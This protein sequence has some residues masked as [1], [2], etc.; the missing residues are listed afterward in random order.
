MHELEKHGDELTFFALE[1]QFR[2]VHIVPWRGLDIALGAF[3]LRPQLSAAAHGAFLS[4]F[5]RHAGVLAFRLTLIHAIP[6]A[7][8]PQTPST[9]SASARIF[10]TPA[11]SK[12]CRRH[13]IVSAVQTILGAALLFLFGLGIRNKFRM[14]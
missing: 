9:S 8:A 5:D 7:S 2:R 6:S 12:P 4:C 3:K 11:S 10:S 14:K 13:E 1:L